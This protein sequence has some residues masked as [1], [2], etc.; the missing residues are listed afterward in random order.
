MYVLFFGLHVTNNL[1]VYN[2]QLRYN[3]TCL[4][5]TSL[6]FTTCLFL[7]IGVHA[8]RVHMWMHMYS[9]IYVYKIYI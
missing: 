7:G 8:H 5:F 2:L 6:Q 9:H 4:Q 3:V 1:Q